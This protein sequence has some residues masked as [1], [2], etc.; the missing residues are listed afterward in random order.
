M[1]FSFLNIL[2]PVTI[3]L[4][5]YGLFLIFYII[6]ALFNVF[7]LVKYG[8]AGLPLYSILFIF[9]GGTVLL[10]AMSILFLFNYDWTYSIRLNEFDSFFHFNSLFNSEFK[11]L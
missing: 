4:G 10:I 7:H 1:N 3:V 6:Y 11:P 9:M 2:I 5:F 8:L